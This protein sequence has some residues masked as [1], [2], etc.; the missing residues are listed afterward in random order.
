MTIPNAPSLDALD[1]MGGD[2]IQDL[3]PDIIAK[4]YSDAKDRNAATSA[5]VAKLDAAVLSKY[6]AEI[7]TGYAAKGDP[8]GVV[9]FDHASHTVKID[10]PK[11]VDWDADKLSEIETVLSEQWG[12]DPAEFIDTKRSVSESKF[13][14][15]PSPITKLFMP[16]RTV[17]ASKTKISI[18][19][20]KE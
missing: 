5:A 20:T 10:R 2:T 19:P 16:A 13:Q 12:S 4:L 7:A 18:E 11:R 15:W 9:K 14:A 1:S 6:T 3:P 17:K 8:T